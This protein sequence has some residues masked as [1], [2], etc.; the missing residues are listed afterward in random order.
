VK[1]LSAVTRY[2]E[3]TVFLLMVVFALI[4]GLVNGSFITMN[5]LIVILNSAIVLLLMAIGESFVLIVGEIDVS[6][7]SIIGISA[8]V[9]GMGLMHGEPLGMV[10]LLT[11]L[12]GLVA[13]II[14]GL[15]VSF[16]KIP[17]IIMTLGTMGIIRGTMIM[18]TGGK[19]IEDIPKSFKRLSTETFLGLSIPVWMGLIC[20]IVTVLFLTQSK[21]GRYFYAVGDNADGAK[22]IGI[23]VRLMKLI[24]FSISGVAAAIAG[25]VFVMNIGFVP[26]DTGSG[27]ELEVIAAA[28]L[29]GVSLSGGIGSVVGAGL[30]AIFFTMID[31]SLVYLKIP[32]F[33]NDAIS[34]MLLLVIVLIDYKLQSLSG[35]SISLFKT[36]RNASSDASFVKKEA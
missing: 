16:L 15:G 29:G 6:V 34:G 22:L 32:G 11:L 19:W 4:V 26:N 18:Y 1:L 27:M 21:A 12:T 31:S 3:L 36:K 8:A 17:A 28:V 7:G 25:L 33:W 23:P 2:R 9:A 30:G 35:R 10:I 5:S 13:G 24:A 20:L 14:N